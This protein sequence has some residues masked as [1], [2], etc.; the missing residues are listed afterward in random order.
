M[1]SKLNFNYPMP[2]TRVSTEAVENYLKTIYTL[3]TESEAERIEAGASQQ[4]IADA[5]GVSISGVSKMLRSLAK[6]ELIDYSPY[7]PA[8]LTERGEKIAL[9][10]IRHHR[11]I[12]L[13]LMKTLG[14]GWDRV[15][16]EADRLEHYIS[17]EMEERIEAALGFPT[18]DPHGDPIPTRD[19]RMPP[20]SR[21]TLDFLGRPG[22]HLRVE[23]IADED[24]LLLRYAEE[25]GLVPGAEIMVTEREQ[26]GGSLIF[27]SS[28]GESHRISPDA[29]KRVY[30]TA[31]TE[32]DCGEPLPPSVDKTGKR[33]AE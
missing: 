27:D 20:T 13:Y 5:L 1:L 16:R 14:Y 28:A 18:L 22:V 25:R 8:R 31:R 26:F 17:E 9:E 2:E 23:R 4:R 33:G 6:S 11:L 12:E 3:S 24:E 21:L 19:G 29:A 7:Q 10:I 32:S 30:V 15:H